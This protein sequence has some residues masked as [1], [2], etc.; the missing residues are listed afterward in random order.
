MNAATIKV[1]E[2]TSAPLKKVR[3]RCQ[4]V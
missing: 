1:T 2:S 4:I 3:T